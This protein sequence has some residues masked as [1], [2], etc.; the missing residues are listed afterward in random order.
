MLNKIDE[1]AVKEK[2]MNV[3]VAVYTKKDLLESCKDMPFDK[4][5]Y[6]H[7]KQSKMPIQI[8]S[9][10]LFID[11]EGNTHLIKNRFGKPGVVISPST[12][13]KIKEL[14]NIAE[15]M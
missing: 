6:C 12:Y 14:K 4:L 5:N 15:K 10:V 11:D 1:A 3:D 9:L 13:H 7:F 2:L 8:A